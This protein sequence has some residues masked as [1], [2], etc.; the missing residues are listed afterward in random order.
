MSGSPK[1]KVYNPSGEYIGCVKYAE[2]AAALV[3]LY[4]DGAKVKYQHSKVLWHEGQESI[5]AGE[6]YD[7]AGTIIRTREHGMHAASFAKV[8]AS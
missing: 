5:G 3:A 1:F 7:E 6:S 2:D 8:Y 4:G